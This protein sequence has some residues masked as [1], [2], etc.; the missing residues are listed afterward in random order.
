[1]SESFAHLLRV[2]NSSP[3]APPEDQYLKG[4]LERSHLDAGKLISVSTH[5]S[6][7]T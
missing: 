2:T 3:V 6:L 5:Y 4:A 1:M 7:T